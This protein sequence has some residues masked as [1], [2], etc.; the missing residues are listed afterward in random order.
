MCSLLKET[1]SLSLGKDKDRKRT[2]LA[3][4]PER[5]GSSSMSSSSV[6]E[7]LRP[8]HREQKEKK[9]KEEK[10]RNPFNLCGETAKIRKIAEKS[11]RESNLF[12]GR[13]FVPGGALVQNKKS[14]S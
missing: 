4:K 1:C 6:V 13:A 7:K 11:N 12:S 3:A 8:I 10:E 2:E 5:V 9:K 14:R